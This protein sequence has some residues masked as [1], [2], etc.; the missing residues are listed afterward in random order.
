MPKITATTYARAAVAAV[1]FLVAMAAWS[2]RARGTDCDARLLVANGRL[3]RTR[4]QLLLA[5]SR[6][7][8]LE[9]SG[10]VRAAYRARVCDV[11]IAVVVCATVCGASLWC[12]S[13]SAAVARTQ[14]ERLAR[15]EIEAAAL[16][17]AAADLSAQLGVRARDLERLHLEVY[18]RTQAAA[19]LNTALAEMARDL[20][21]RTADAGALLKRATM[22]EVTLQGARQE[23]AGL[24][25]V[26]GHLEDELRL[27]RHAAPL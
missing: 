7:C 24:R 25:T 22:A 14:G 3:A 6:P 16:R 20:E 10:A 27:L 26:V 1:A 15:A 18:T 21:A 13:R 8:C 5:E 2:A 4:E 11:C 9:K 23:A 12:A 17:D 19:D